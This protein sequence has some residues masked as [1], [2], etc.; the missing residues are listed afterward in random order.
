MSFEISIHYAVNVWVVCKDMLFLTKIQT[1]NGVKVTKIQAENEAKVTKIQTE[2][3]A[4]VTK[5][6]TEI[7][8]GLGIRVWIEPVAMQP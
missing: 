1:E 7:L 2:N 3:E 5:I 4:E 6:Q 8:R